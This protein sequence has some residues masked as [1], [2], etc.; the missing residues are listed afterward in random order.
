MQQ[1]QS[2][3]FTGYLLAPHEWL[4]IGAYRL[5]NKRYRYR[6]GDQRVVEAEALSV[7][8]QLFCLLFPLVIGLITALLLAGV[9]AFSF[10]GGQYPRRLPDYLWSAPLWHHSLHLV[11]ILLLTYT[12]LFSFYD[13]LAAFQ[14]VRQQKSRQ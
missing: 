8:Q 7:R 4:R 13:V 3:K 1:Q 5:I 6:L 9:W 12:L 14:L 10:I 2:F 11:W